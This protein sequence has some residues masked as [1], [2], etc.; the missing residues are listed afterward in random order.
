MQ[1]NKVCQTYHCQA[2]LY[3]TVTMLGSYSEGL[4]PALDRETAPIEHEDFLAPHDVE[5]YIVSVD[6]KGTLGFI[7]GYI[8]KKGRSK[9]HVIEVLSD[10]ASDAYLWYLREKGVS[11][12]FAGKENLNCSLI[13]E[14]LRTYFG[15]ERLKIRFYF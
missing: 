9:V 14:K 11:Y 6:P 10:E 12:I 1:K 4:A 8:E 2:T 13:L 5:N 15:I 7:D 3:G